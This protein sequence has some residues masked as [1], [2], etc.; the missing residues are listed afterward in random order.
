MLRAYLEHPLARASTYGTEVEFNLRLEAVRVKG[1]VDRVCRY[2]DRTTLVDYKT[3]ARL[4]AR[5]RSAYAEQLRLYGLAADRGLLP[6][7][8][9]PRLILF[10]LRH[11]EAI[12]V[13]P[14]PEAAEA[15]VARAA[16]RIEGGDFALG[17]EHRD[18]PC[19]LCAYRPICPDRR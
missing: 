19:F 15:W 8:A 6:G 4:D 3:N 12:E 7:G 5:L 11:A 16:A 1:V 18:R 14:D 17:P 13:Q 2:D 9:G 10:D